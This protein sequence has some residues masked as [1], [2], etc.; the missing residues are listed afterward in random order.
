MARDVVH[1][2]NDSEAEAIALLTEVVAAM[3][4]SCVRG[5]DATGGAA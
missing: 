1:P 4:S 3:H 5:L 2:M